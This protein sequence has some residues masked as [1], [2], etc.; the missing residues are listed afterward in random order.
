MTESLGMGM[1]NA[2]E[3]ARMLKNIFARF[4][5]PFLAFKADVGS[6]K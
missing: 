3:R 1:G 5:R 6:K 2:G 4:Y